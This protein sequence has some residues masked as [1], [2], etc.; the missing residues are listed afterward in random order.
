MDVGEIR[1]L[2]S[3]FR[4]GIEIAH[5]EGL[6]RTKPFSDFPNAC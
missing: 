5:A 4:Q 6:F 2:S 3:R 1:Y